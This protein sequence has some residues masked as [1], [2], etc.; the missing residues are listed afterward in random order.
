MKNATYLF[1]RPSRS[2]KNSESRWTAVAQLSLIYIS[3]KLA[4]YKLP[5]Y[6]S[7]QDGYLTEKGKLPIANFT[8]LNTVCENP[9]KG[10]VFDVNDF[11]VRFDGLKIDI[12]R[13]VKT[14]SHVKKVTF[15]EVKTLSESVIRN[16]DLY[17]NLREYLISCACECQ[18]YYLLSHGHEKPRDW[19]ELSKRASNI[20]LWEDMFSVMAKTPFA[21]LIADNL[22]EYCEPPEKRG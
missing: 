10:E 2:M 8:Y 12:M 15:I 13:I 5:V 20:I 9:L 1:E 4:G 21:Y 18:L 6:G 11:D 22:N 17:E 14:D 7:D 19:P 3:A 16:I